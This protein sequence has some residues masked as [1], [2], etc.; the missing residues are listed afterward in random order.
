MTPSRLKIGA[1]ATTIRRRAH[2]SSLVFAL[3]QRRLRVATRRGLQPGGPVRAVLGMR[4]PLIALSYDDGPSHLNTPQLL[5][6]LHEQQA[7]AT[8]FVVGNQVKGNE[9]LLARVAAEGHEIGNHSF[10]HTDPLELDHDGLR[11][12]IERTQKVISRAVAEPLLFRPPFGKKPR[13]AACVCAE[14]GITAVLWSIDSGDTR[15]FTTERIVGEVVGRA[16][17]GDIVLMHDGGEHRPR[18]LEA[19]RRIVEDLAGRGYRF[20]TVSDLLAA[21]LRSHTQP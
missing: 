10:S 17:P 2:K 19:T 1:L 18:T 16:R 8:F 14:R 7:R 12:E 13:A 4:E 6:I 5:D 9:R 20:V 11:S 3:N 15:D 21:G